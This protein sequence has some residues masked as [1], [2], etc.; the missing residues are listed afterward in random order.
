MLPI[1]EEGGM[2]KASIISHRNILISNY[3]H[4]LKGRNEVDFHQKHVINGQFIAM[5]V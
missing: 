4:N 3:Y 5:S 1:K 2:S